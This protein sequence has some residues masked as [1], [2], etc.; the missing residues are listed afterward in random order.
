MMMSALGATA[1]APKSEPDGRYAPIVLKN[2]ATENS[3]P[4]IGMLFAKEGI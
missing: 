1:D 3:T 4:K 2:S